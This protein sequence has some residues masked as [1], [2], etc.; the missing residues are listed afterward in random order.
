MSPLD[1]SS[2]LLY[3]IPIA[4]SARIYGSFDSLLARRNHAIDPEPDDAAILPRRRTAKTDFG[5]RLVVA[6]SPEQLDAAAQ[7]VRQR[8]AWRGYQLPD[9]KVIA[10]QSR[11]RSGQ[12]I[13]FLA[14]SGP[15]AVGTLTLGLDG[16]A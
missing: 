15:A 1:L 9:A 14:A 13:T 10:E 4:L 5:L 8:Y 16:P 7:L 3:G 6:K 11:K 2:A 12:E